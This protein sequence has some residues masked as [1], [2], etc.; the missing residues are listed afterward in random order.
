MRAATGPIGAFLLILLVT[1]AV[2]QE[3][4]TTTFV[5]VQYDND[6]GA[7]I[8]YGTGYRVSG[9]VWTIGRLVA[10]EFGSVEV[11]LAAVYSPGDFSFGVVAGPNV[12]WAGDEGA[13]TYIVGGAGGLVGWTQ[14]QLGLGLV[15]GAKYKFALEGGMLYKDGWQA[16]LWL[17]K[18]F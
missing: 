16:G 1:G 12:E 11:D 2:A 14:P 6:E 5:G 10:G 9:P 7:A 8:T 15:A 3:T 13:A 17:T 18:G 4:T